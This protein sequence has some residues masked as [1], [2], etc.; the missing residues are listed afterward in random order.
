[1]TDPIKFVERIWAQQ[2]TDG[3]A[4]GFI[5]QKNWETGEW[6]DYPSTAIDE[7]AITELRDIYFCPN[8]FSGNRRTQSNFI[9]SRWLY[10]DL[11]EVDPAG[12]TDVPPTLAW[13]T[14][15]GRWQAL[16]L[17][18]RSL[19]RQRFE[20][21]NKR[22][23]YH[24]KADRGG[25]S[26][27]KV[28]RVPGTVSTK[29][30]KSRNK[31]FTVRLVHKGKKYRVEDLMRLLPRADQ[32]RG[33]KVE[34]IF[35]SGGADSLPPRGAVMKL[36]QGRLPR[37]AKQLLRAKGAEGDDRSARLW[38][39]Y[40]LLL[41]AGITPLHILVLVRATVWNKYAGQNRELLQLQTEIAKAAE[42]HAQADEM[43]RLVGATNTPGKTKARRNGSP[44]NG[45][46]GAGDSASVV[47]GNGRKRS[48]ASRSTSSS[49]RRAH[50][51]GR[52]E[53]VAVPYARGVH[54]YALS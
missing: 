25:W 47:R 14:S 29:Y 26:S 42:K 16:W 52:A 51:E 50:G 39:L 35:G 4:Y 54:A 13:E 28:L 1:M 17:L 36:V 18:N 31:R 32:T 3:S 40:N 2:R 45:D 20:R 43:A 27:T 34:A 6:R 8:L 44:N 21:L 48:S 9:S 5:S 12:I 53:D 41:Q 30:G 19:S 23:T 33:V 38:E 49:S 37:R 11:D 22:L 46:R 7:V 15:P 10:A 24:L